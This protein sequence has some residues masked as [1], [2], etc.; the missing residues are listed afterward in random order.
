MRG[1]NVLSIGLGLRGVGGG[2]PRVE[3]PMATPI[4]LGATYH[5]DGDNLGDVAST[6]ATWVDQV[7]A[8]PLVPTANDPLVASWQGQKA[9]TLAVNS[10]LQQATDN[11]V[12]AGGVYTFLAWGQS[13][14][15]TGGCIFSLRLS[16]KFRAHYAFTSA[17]TTY[18]SGDGVGAGQN[19]TI[20]DGTWKEAPF[21]AAWVFNGT[22]LAP[23]FYVN[24][25]ANAITGGTQ[26]TED[27]ATGAVMGL[28]GASAQ[29]FSGVVGGASLIPS[30]LTAD[31]VLDLYERYTADRYG[32]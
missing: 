7:S 31:Q 23:D 5:W 21:F 10:N 13:D 14:D 29:Q 2:T 8:L 6:Q 30:A 19:T 16:T 17:G 22:G 15:A 11:L 4:T 12:A 25:V 24:G 32:F 1:S 20:A 18:I 28:T 9:I 27:G 26:G 3:V